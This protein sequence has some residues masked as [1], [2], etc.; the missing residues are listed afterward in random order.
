MGSEYGKRANKAEVEERRERV[1]AYIRQYITEHGYSP[2][3]TDIAKAMGMS[4]S[5]AHS[6]VIKLAAR[7]AVK[8]TLGIARSIVLV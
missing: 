4:T 7:G 5:Q 3:Y 6:Y 2:A 8:V 1:M